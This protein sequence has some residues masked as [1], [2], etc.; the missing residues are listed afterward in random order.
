MA[1]LDVDMYQDLRIAADFASF[2]D[3]LRPFER[4]G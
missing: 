2:V 4:P 1:W 3:S